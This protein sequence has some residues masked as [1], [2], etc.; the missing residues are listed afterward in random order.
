M[1]FRFEPAVWLGVVRALVVFGSAFGLQLTL[2]QVAA[3][4]GLTEA[5]TSAV[6]RSVATPNAK[7]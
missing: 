2:E 4:Y 5:V 1:S 3:I 7:L 6:Q